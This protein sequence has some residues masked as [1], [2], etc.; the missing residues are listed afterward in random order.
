MRQGFRACL[1]VTS[2]LFICPLFVLSVRARD[3]PDTGKTEAR[4]AQW[5]GYA[6]PADKYVRHID[7]EKGWTF[8]RPASWRENKVEKGQL[9]L[10]SEGDAANIMVMTE[11][12]PEGYGVANYTTAMLKGLR[13]VRVNLETMTVRRVLLGGLDA[14]E[15]ALEREEDSGQ[16]LRQVFWVTQ[17]GP[18]AYVF[19]LTGAAEAFEKWEPYF[20]RAMLSARIT[21]AGHWD[22]EFE[23]LRA[24][25]VTLN[26]GAQMN[27]ARDAMALRLAADIRRGQTNAD[28]SAQMRELMGMGAGTGKAPESLPESLMDMLT[29]SDPQVRAAAAWAFGQHAA[30]LPAGDG[31]TLSMATL[32]WVLGDPAPYTSAVAAR[33]LN[34]LAEKHA[35]AVLS[36]VRPGLN[37]LAA[38]PTALLHLC[39]ALDEQTARPLVEELLRADT[40]A[41]NAAGL[42]IALILPLRGLLLPLAKLSLAGDERL[43]TLLAENVR[44]RQTADTLP[45]VQAL[46][47]GETEY[48]AMRMLGDIGAP[49]S[50]PALEKRL[51]EIDA[52]FD[53]DPPPPPPPA[54]GSKAGA[55]RTTFT[56]PAKPAGTVTSAFTPGVGEYTASFRHLPESLRLALVRGAVSD[57]MEKIRFRAAYANA[58]NDAKR[59]GVLQDARKSQV[60]DWADA[61]LAYREPATAFANLAPDPAQFANTPT[62]G[63]KLFPGHSYLYVSAPRFEQTLARLDRA[64]SGVQMETVRDQMT[65]ALLLNTYKAQMS[66]WLNAAA[67]DSVSAATGVDL[68]APLSLAQWVEPGKSATTESHSALILRVRDRARLEHLVATWQKQFGSLD[69]LVTTTSVITRMAGALPAIVPM[70]LT[71]S[72]ND[73]SVMAGTGQRSP[74]RTGPADI[75]LREERI[76]TLPVTIVEKMTLSVTGVV[77]RERTHIAYLGDTAVITPTRE[78]L[79]DLLGR[80]AAQ[81]VIAA[82]ESFR[83]TQNQTGEITYF[84]RLGD[85]TFSPAV[86]A[87]AA[88]GKSKPG[89][90][91]DVFFEFPGEALGAESGALRQAP[92]SLPTSWETKFTLR[93]KD[94]DWV[95]SLRPFAARDLAIPR[96]LL[97]RS[98][99][100]YAGAV[101]APEKLWK[102]METLETRLSDPDEE[103]KTA[104]QKA[105]AKQLDSEMKQ[106]LMPRLQG[107]MAAALLS[108][109][110]VFSKDEN[111]TPSFVL[112]ARLKDGEAARQFRAGKLFT[113]AVMVKDATAF[114]GPVATLPPMSES[115]HFTV[116]DEYL[117]FADSVATLKLLEEKEKFAATRDYQRAIEGTPAQLALFATYSID[118]A[119]AEARKVAGKDENSLRMLNVISAMMHAFHSQRAW[120]AAR[121]ETSGEVALDAALSLSF[122]REGRYTVGSAGPKNGEIDL[123]NALIT[124]RG[125]NILQP[126]RMESLRLKVTTREPGLTPRI[127]EDITPFAWHTVETAGADGALVY[128]NT[129]RRMPAGLTTRLPVAAPEFREY[130]QA[131]P[132]INTDA[133]EVVKLAR[134]I[135]GK[136]RDGRSVSRKLAEWT[137]T[138]LKWKRVNSTSAQ[139]LASREADC[140]EHAELYTAMAR[141]LG[142]PARV[143]SGLAYS[144]GSFGAHAWVEIWLGK[145][146]ELDPTWGLPDYVDATHLRFADDGFIEYTILGQVNLEVLETRATVADFQRDPA[147]LVREI[148]AADAASMRALAFDAGLAIEQALGAG[149][150]AALDEKPRAAVIAAFDRAVGDLNQKWTGDWEWAEPHLLH[151]ETSAGRVITLARLGQELFRFHLSQRDGAWYITE[152]EDL[153][154]YPSLLGDPLRAAL[155]PGQDPARIMARRFID[156]EKALAQLEQLIARTGESAPLLLMKTRLL[157]TK[158]NFEESERQQAAEKATE[159]SAGPEE[160]K[161]EKKTDTEAPVIAAPKSPGPV[162][163]LL[164]SITTRWP[165]YAPAWRALGDHYDN[166]EDTGEKSLAP[167]QRYAQLAPR[168][169]RPHQE[170]GAV[171]ARMDKLPEAEAAYREASKR[172]AHI[173]QQIRLVSFLLW[174]DLHD[175]AVGALRDT[176]RAATGQMA[177]QKQELDDVFSS[178]GFDTEVLTDEAEEEMYPRVEKLLLAFPKELA[179]HKEGLRLLAHCQDMQDHVDAALKTMR[180]VVA[181]GPESGDYKIITSLHRQLRQYPLA[182]AAAA[183]AVKLDRENAAAHFERARVLALAGRKREAV[184]TLKRA[185]ELSEYLRAS[186][187]NPDF[188]SLADLPAFKALA[189]KEESGQK[190]PP[191][192]EK[193]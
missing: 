103:Q 41:Q 119:F 141:A 172:D 124:P 152:V 46:A 160:K 38:S 164:L 191:A 32:V 14:R 134:E 125:L 10:I 137:H 39:T 162:E 55:G 40:A 112:A 163:T 37:A 154:G 59:Q 156:P 45:A 75:F 111:A 187:E 68:G 110:S 143:V 6:L 58:R 1:F 29:D 11:D 80:A 43:V 100:L 144:G 118:A 179:G 104:D 12:I 114:G 4:A 170:M 185:I 133:P 66:G 128:R 70:L 121:A 135:A 9:Q 117:V 193:P 13:E 177:G 21:A 84:S 120:V 57:A 89:A 169:P 146:V 23:T 77:A 22:T 155:T 65:F 184:A 98:A 189:P 136:D 176:F 93:M 81:P 183:Q 78:S 150:F 90:P 130:L 85:L 24:R 186:L 83:Q 72:L 99:I 31:L 26:A 129:A 165:D 28:V 67:T 116:T 159:K 5:E 149:K 95:G 42:R 17:S 151:Q 30:R 20:K 168:D 97:P 54:P 52:K 139:T 109:S 47:K 50:L 91:E 173:D 88:A 138:N 61:M 102:A 16:Q 76:G 101:L 192:T 25:L 94:N 188:K 36:A 53:K 49:A 115:L 107:E 8:W 158:L 51:K 105:A 175:K 82:N 127:R 145:W 123:L 157:E 73:A 62:T 44:R 153:D 71:A 190:A 2:L 142:L 180:R 56:P 33:A 19:L 3:A 74:R 86:K 126:T 181:L 7:R 148:G 34:L 131:T 96:E 147:R 64:F 27:P 18:R 167:L 48:A 15:I 60:A 174:N 171:L 69:S 161:E 35:A 92:E 79:L 178:L 106:N 140:L 113:S 166:D 122:G 182:L 87:P 108:L 63:E 132:R